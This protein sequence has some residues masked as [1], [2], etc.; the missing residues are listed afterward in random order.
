MMVREVSCRL[1]ANA[2]QFTFTREQT[3][4]ARGLQT[5]TRPALDVLKTAARAVEPS[6]GQLGSR[7]VDLFVLRTRTGVS[8]TAN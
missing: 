2:E 8:A 6:S 5:Q 1:P 3:A 4:W 7:T